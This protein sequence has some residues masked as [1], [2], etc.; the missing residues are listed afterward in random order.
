MTSGRRIAGLMVALAG[1]VVVAWA[2]T[3]PLRTRENG[4]GILRLTW[5]A[6]PERIETCRPQTEEELA[7]VPA[8]MR[9]KV[10]C[11]GESARYRLQVS[12]DGAVLLDEIV[13]GGGWRRDRPLHV[14]HEI[15]QAPGAAAIRIVFERID[16]PTPPS[17]GT[18]SAAP[19]RPEAGGRFVSD[20]PASITLE[21]EFQ[22]R[23]G[24]VSLVT[25]DAARHTLVVVEG[26]M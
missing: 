24:A 25:Y 13:Q 21:R 1:T 2:S 9:Q 18:S 12:R 7:R 3:V 20:L 11:T 8:H 15:A 22:F 14:F 17:D 23:S 6:R 5:S 16:H 19:P 4:M 10:V 26:G